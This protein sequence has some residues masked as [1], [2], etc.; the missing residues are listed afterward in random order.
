M[1]TLKKIISWIFFPLTMVLL[2]IYWTI[3]GFISMDKLGDLLIAAGKQL[4]E[5]K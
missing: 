3:I 2:C 5:R 1:K 4:K